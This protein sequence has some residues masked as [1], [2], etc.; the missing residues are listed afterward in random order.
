VPAPANG[1]VTAFYR[2]VKG[3]GGVARAKEL[4]ANI[5]AFQNA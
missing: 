4:I 2:A 1:A 5:E 3:I